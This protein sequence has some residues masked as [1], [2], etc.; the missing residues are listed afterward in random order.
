[1]G[2]PFAD[3]HRHGLMKVL[4]EDEK[5]IA[6]SIFEVEMKNPAKLF[7][8]LSQLHYLKCDIEGYEVPVIPAMLP[9]IEKH[10]PVVQ[11]ETSG[12]NQKILYQLFSGLGYQLFYVGNNGLVPLSRQD[13]DLPGDLIGIPP[14]LQSEITP[15][16]AQS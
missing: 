6:P 4:T 9:V 11:I 3:Q 12:N 13:M 15:L 2:L 14:A 16:V 8:S 5:T 7:D 1:M 10:L